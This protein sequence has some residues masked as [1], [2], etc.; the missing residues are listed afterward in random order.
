M[1][2]PA[3]SGRILYCKLSLTGDENLD[4]LSRKRATGQ[5]PYH[6]TINQNYDELLFNAYRILGTHIV[7]RVVSGLDRVEFA[8]GEIRSLTADELQK[9]FC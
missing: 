3:T 2:L 9:L 4:L 8:N 5:F 6:S 7:G 1:G